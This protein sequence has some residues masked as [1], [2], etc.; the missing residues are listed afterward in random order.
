M[1]PATTTSFFPAKPLGCYGDGGALMT[2]DV[3][4]AELYR[5]LRAHGTGGA[6]Y[7][8]VRVGFNSRLDTL[9]AAILLAKLPALDTE[10]AA[11][12]RL[13]RRYDAALAGAVETPPRPA[14]TASAWAQ[15]TIQSP[16]RDRIAQHLKSKGIPTAIYYPKPMHLQPAYAGHGEGEGS[17]PVSETLSARVLSL[18][19]HA[20][21]DDATADR[22]A[23]EVRAALGHG[24]I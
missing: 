13:A 5:S 23:A 3:T 21:M 14:G 4:R 20:D 15:Y 11:R 7:D 6:K 24:R 2:D 12:E 22:V 8:I 1:A 9:Q 17:L 16:A 18:P 19:F 10:I